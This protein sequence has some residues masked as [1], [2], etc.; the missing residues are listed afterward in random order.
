MGLMQIEWFGIPVKKHIINWKQAVMFSDLLKS[1]PRMQ[2]MQVT[3]HGYFDQRLK[4][5][6]RK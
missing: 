1:M 5:P 3:N 2:F 6:I 4:E